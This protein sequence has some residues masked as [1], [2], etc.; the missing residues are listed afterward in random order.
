[1]YELFE[2]AASFQLGGLTVYLYGLFVALGALAASLALAALAKKRALPVGTSA[3]V[4][5]LALPLG[6]VL[7]RALYCL[8]DTNF[9]TVASLK[10]ALMVSGGGY[11]M[12]GAL[13]GAVLA[14]LIGAKLL[15]AKPGKMLDALIPALL[16][17]L[18]FE[19]AGEGFTAL[20]ISRPLRGELFKGMF[21]SR[22]DDYDAYLNTWI[23]ESAAAL[24]LFAVSLFIGKKEK[25]DGHTALKTA[26]LFA[27][28][29][30]LFESLRYDQ[31]LK[32]SFVGVQHVLSAL[33]LCALVIC[34]AV[35]ARRQGRARGLSIFSIAF[36]PV[37]AGLLV[38][39]EFWIDRTDI[40]RYLL[41]AAYVL[42]LSVPVVCGFRLDKEA[43]K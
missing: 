39:I 33:V 4:T 28:S 7:A 32:Y 6:F 41:Y 43:R 18:L 20:G 31:H 24:I 29:Q 37:L 3:L 26:L 17:F 30:V 12:C 16:L 23:L 38:L 8:L 14:G 1:M 5:A 35:K 2:D 22:A 11:A 42:L 10:A 36:L 13:L 9:S 34:L 40:S 27:A 19:R 25:R 15:K 21:L